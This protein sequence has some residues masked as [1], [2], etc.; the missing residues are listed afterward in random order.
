MEQQKE[1][2]WKA[3]KKDTAQQIHGRSKEGEPSLDTLPSALAIQVLPMG[4]I[5]REQ[6]WSKVDKAIREIQA[7]GL[8]YT[9]GPFETVVEGPMN[10]LWELAAHVHRIVLEAGAPTVATYIKFWSGKNIGTSEEKTSPYR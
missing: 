7:S 8:P 1:E 9:V 3:A 6:V 5:S 10:Q 2:G 4:L